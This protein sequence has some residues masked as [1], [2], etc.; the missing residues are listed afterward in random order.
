MNIRAVF[1]QSEQTFCA[2]FR[3]TEDRLPADFGEVQKVTEYVG[4][5]GYDGDYTVTPKVEPQTLPTKGKV[6][7]DNMS[8]KSIPFYDVSNT[9]GGSTVYIG[10][11]VENGNQ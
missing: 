4:G 1:A 7:L 2:D 9:S 3:E 5:E 10:I 6:M 11:E 8:I